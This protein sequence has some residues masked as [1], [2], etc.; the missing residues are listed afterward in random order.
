MFDD[1][2]RQI[3]V[4]LIANI[5]VSSSHDKLAFPPL[6]TA[7]PYGTVLFVSAIDGGTC[8]ISPSS[9]IAKFAAVGDE[10]VILLMGVMSVG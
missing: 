3:V 2:P 4:N 9:V 10:F 1:S 6:K 7:I 5:F 8:S